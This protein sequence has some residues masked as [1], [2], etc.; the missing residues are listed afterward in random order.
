MAD[1]DQQGGYSSFDDEGDGDGGTIIDVSGGD[2]NL[3]DQLEGGNLEDQLEDDLED[4]LEGYNN[5]ANE[6]S[7]TETIEQA[8]FNLMDSVEPLQQQQQQQQQQPQQQQQSILWV[9]RC[10]EPVAEG[11]IRLLTEPDPTKPWSDR[12]FTFSQW[13]TLMTSKEYAA[14]IFY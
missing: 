8:L 5:S 10:K 12:D 14:P 6:L 13:M 2:S 9:D 1:A 7:Y 4:E 3:E 11:V